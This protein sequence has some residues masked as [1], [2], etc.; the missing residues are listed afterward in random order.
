MPDPGEYKNEQDFMSDCMHQVKKVEGKPQDQ[1]VAQCLSMW[2]QEHG[3][4]KPKKKRSKG[5]FEIIREIAG[6]LDENA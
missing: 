1:A 3:G 4:K 6:R 2:R 5:A